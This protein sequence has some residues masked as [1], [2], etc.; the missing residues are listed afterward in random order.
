MLSHR[1]PPKRIAR[2]GVALL[3]TLGLLGVIA[4][5][6]AVARGQP[7]SLGFG[8]G[9]GV[10]VSAVLSCA[11]GVGG[12][13][14]GGLV[15]SRRPRHLFGWLLLA[16]GAEFTLTRA[17]SAFASDAY[18]HSRH[19]SILA[20]VALVATAPITAITFV[21]VPLLMAVFPTGV[22][23]GRWRRLILWFG[24]AALAV[25]VLASVFN[26][27]LEPGSS[28]VGYVNPIGFR[29][30]SGVIH[31][32]VVIAPSVLA[33]LSLIVVGDVVMRWRRS[34]G[35]V[36]QQMKFFGYAA[37]LVVVLFV[38]LVIFQGRL[39]DLAQ[40]SW[41]IGY[42]VGLN[43]LAVATGLAV[44]RFGLYEID[45]L[46]SRTVTY[47]L[48]TGLLV[49]LYIGTVTLTT[50]VLPLQS[51]VG[52]AAS[53]LVAAALFNPLRKSVQRL[54]DRRFNRRQ[55]D[56]EAT[57][58]SFTA[59]L[60]EAVDLPAVQRD[61]LATV[62][63][64]FEPSHATLWMQRRGHHGTGRHAAGPLTDQPAL[65]ER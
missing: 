55:Y 63:E 23:S 3:S 31:R 20:Q 2:Y 41:P 36:R 56:A 40:D 43:G 25:D 12:L 38:A 6:V 28:A 44:Y 57:I 45:R 8:S 35:I 7:S 16:M 42:L 39:P 50:K 65:I 19:P 29:S 47:A 64:A 11:D 33:A 30:A 46:M 51:P 18:A 24:A 1:V 48:V 60:R 53:T 49:G 52:V 21:T 9:P 59:R 62:T 22:V 26:P 4:T 32:A 61:L 27:G 14:V 10:R 17:V 34:S 37:I 5:M 54:V 58:S 15:A 13:V